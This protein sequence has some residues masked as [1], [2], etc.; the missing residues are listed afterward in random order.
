MITNEQILSSSY[1]TYRY[2]VDEFVFNKTG[3]GFSKP[4]I[5]SIQLKNPMTGIAQQYPNISLEDFEGQVVYAKWK[6][7]L[8]ILGR[9]WYDEEDSSWNLGMNCELSPGGITQNWGNNIQEIYGEGAYAITTRDTFDSPSDDVVTTAT[10]VLK[11]LTEEQI[12][13]VLHNLKGKSN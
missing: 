3:Q 4:Q 10:E 9:V 13:R 11:G 7:G 2:K 12:A 8:T 5:K 1:R 6:N